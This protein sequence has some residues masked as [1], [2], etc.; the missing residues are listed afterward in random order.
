MMSTGQISGQFWPIHGQFYSYIEGSSV[1]R[2]EPTN[3][4]STPTRTQT[5]LQ[6][7]YV[8]PHTYYDRMESTDF[9]QLYASCI[10]LVRA[11]PLPLVDKCL[12]SKHRRRMNHVNMGENTYQCRYFNSAYCTAIVCLSP[13][14]GVERSVGHEKAV[15]GHC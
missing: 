10:I 15:M 8:H 7:L 14:I 12:E 6:S 3:S 4:S 2:T 9:V 13:T 5:M 1:E 11:L